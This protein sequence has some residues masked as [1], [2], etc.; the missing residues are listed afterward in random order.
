[1]A[2]MPPCYFFQKFG[3][4]NNR[5]CQYLHVDAETLKIKD[6]A[7]YDRGFC[8]HGKCVF[9]C[10]CVCVCETTCIIVDNVLRSTLS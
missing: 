5:D 7:W 2:K 9:E 3:E 6:C 10:V 1:M 4:C 8:K